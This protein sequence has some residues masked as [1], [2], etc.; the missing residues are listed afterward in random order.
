MIQ[1]HSAKNAAPS[2]KCTNSS[3]LFT[4]SGT[5]KGNKVLTYPVGLIT[6]DEAAY[7]GGVAGTAN[8]SF[9]LYTGKNYWTMSPLM[10]NGS[11]AYVYPVGGSGGLYNWSVAHSSY[12]VR[13]VINLKSSVK[14]TGSGTSADPYVAV[15]VS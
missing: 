11:Y 10:F 14:S 7:A 9:Y 2:L 5:T 4:V 12:G 15:S 3:D 1:Y 13:P 6:A 8:S